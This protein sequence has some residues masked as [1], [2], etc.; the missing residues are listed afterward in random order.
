MSSELSLQVDSQSSIPLATQVCQQLSWLIVAGTL[1]EGDELP[2]VLAHPGRLKQIVMNLLMNAYQAIVAS[3]G[4][5]GGLGEIVIRT[6]LEGPQVVVE[7]HDDGAGIAPED[8]SRIFDPFF[9]T[10][11]PGAGTGLG[12]STVFHLVSALGGRVEA[13]SPEG[14][15]ATF[16]ILLPTVPGSP[17]ATEPLA[18]EGA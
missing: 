4:A 16:R 8:M 9:T 3:R 2:P 15:G 12:L 1:S 14:G 18:V 13:E 5:S 11:E 17:P 10:Q 7:V 6:A